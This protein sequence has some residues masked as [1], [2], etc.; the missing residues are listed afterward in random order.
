[1]L[2]DSF[3]FPLSPTL[4]VLTMGTPTVQS[5]RLTKQRQHQVMVWRTL[6]NKD[7]LSLEIISKDLQEHVI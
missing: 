4:V 7:L 1:M 3:S 2:L 6:V 5:W